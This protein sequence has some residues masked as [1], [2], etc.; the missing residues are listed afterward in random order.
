MSCGSNAPEK[1]RVVGGGARLGVDVDGVEALN[2]VVTEWK[3]GCGGRVPSVAGSM[4]EFVDEFKSSS[5]VC[6]PLSRGSVGDEMVEG[7]S[8]Y[9]VKARGGGETRVERSCGASRSWAEG[10]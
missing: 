10:W 6:H 1:V 4:T 9:I 8:M 3:D 5:G 2:A 7:A